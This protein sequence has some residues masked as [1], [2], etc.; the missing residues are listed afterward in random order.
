MGNGKGN[1]VT[2]GERR[3]IATSYAYAVT[4]THNRVHCHVCRRRCQRVVRQ[5][6][7]SSLDSS[8]DLLLT[9][10]SSSLAPFVSNWLS[11]LAAQ[12]FSRLLVGALDSS[13]HA[14]CVAARVPVLLIRSDDTRGGGDDAGDGGDGSAYYRKDYGRF[15]RM[16]VRKVRFLASLLGHIPPGEACGYVMR[17]WS[18]SAGRRPRWCVERRS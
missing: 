5:P 13:L 9:F 14:A 7:A 1:G 16:G 17:I 15:K 3:S 2:D 6:F 8:E 11:A 4:S 12:G 18:F 10:G